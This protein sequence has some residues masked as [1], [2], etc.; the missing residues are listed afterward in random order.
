MR[1]SN[2]KIRLEVVDGLPTV[3]FDHDALR[4]LSVE[5]IRRELASKRATRESARPEPERDSSHASD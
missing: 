3:R 5:E 2:L 4:K 1:K